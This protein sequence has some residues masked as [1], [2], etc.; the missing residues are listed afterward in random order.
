[1]GWP[2]YFSFSEEW[3]RREKE[4]ERERERERVG[5]RDLFVRP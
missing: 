4:R 1:M 3:K 5:R 2:K